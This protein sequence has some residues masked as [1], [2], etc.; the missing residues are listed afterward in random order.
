M[1]CWVVTEAG[2][3][4]TENQCL[5]V[6]DALGI[7]PTIKRIGLKQ[8]WKTLSPWLGFE[9]SW[10]FTGDP[11]APPWPDLLL[12]AG[13]KA[14]AAAR[15]IR[16]QSPK[17]FVVFLQNPR[18]SPHTF[19]LV[20]VPAHDSLRGPNVIVTDAAPNRVTPT[21][22]VEAREKFSFLGNLPKPRVAVLIGGDSRTHRLSSGIML[23]LT[24][25]LRQ[26]STGHGLM[27]TASRRTGEENRKILETNLSESVYL[28]D[29]SGD[30]PYYGLLGWADYII[31]T[32]DSASMLSEAGTTG[33]PVYMVPLEGGSP[34][35]DRLHRRFL[36]KGIVRIF[37]GNLKPY[38]YT[39]LNDAAMVAR[40]I[41]NRMRQ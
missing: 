38:G 27:I 25:Q 34:R 31:V 21:R 36:D 11:L 6:A 41:R 22:L 33:K 39:P 18:I 23:R 29:G 13:R 9:N 7:V 40:E 37:D 3:T 12:A 17:T 4:G 20:A 26:L 28:W 10:I 32:S 5:G 16:A 8:P 15:Y 30:N 19:D 1:K 35:F 24:E 14:V 2:L